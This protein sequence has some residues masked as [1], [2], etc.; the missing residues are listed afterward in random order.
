MSLFN[1]TL[2]WIEASSP[3]ENEYLQAAEEICEYIVPIVN[4]NEA[5]KANNVLQRILVPQRVIQFAVE[6][7]DDN[8]QCQVNTGWR[9][10]HSNVLGPHKGGTRFHP[11]LNLSILKF[12]AL[13]QSFK[14]SLTG[15]SLGAGKGGA[16]FD[17]TQRSENEIRRFSKAYAKGL[18]SH[19]GPTTDVPAGDINVSAKELGYMFAEQLRATG[20]FAGDFSGKPLS[21]GGSKLRV[22]ATGYGLL[23]F[24]ANMLE[25]IHESMEA[26]TVT[27][28]GAGNVAIHAA[29]KAIAMNAKV[30]T[31]SNSRGVF[32]CDQGLTQAHINWLKDNKGKVENALQEL[33]KEH[34]GEYQ[35]GAPW[36]M[37]AD[38]ALP[39][40]TQNE[41]DE[42]DAQQIIKNTRIAL[43][44]G[45]NMPCTKPAIDKLTAS[46]LLYA[47]GKAANA[48][49][50]IL[51]AFEMQQN[52]AMRYDSEETLDERL[53]QRMHEIHKAC[54]TESNHLGNADID[55]VQGA[56]VA[57]FRKLADALVAS[58]F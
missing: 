13:E 32:I 31:L 58:G 45:A 26:K 4:S 12:L 44:E 33:A 41:I 35:K 15:L 24:V 49:G 29:E 55:Y 14:N 11:Q 17:P 5:Y 57:G 36:S 27:I 18:Y 47:P 30:L 16:D 10:Q 52:S 39:C 46:S 23:Y 51:S 28:S 21:L 38:I 50:V 53:Q 19:I 22:E 1:E 8:H 3:H 2:N 20:S 9:V 6:W 48:G 42:K 37:K 7:E 56:N 34:D 54:V 25:Q 43:V 40:A